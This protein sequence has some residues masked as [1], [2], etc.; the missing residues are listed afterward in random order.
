MTLND[1]GRELVGQD[2]DGNVYLRYLIDAYGTAWEI[3][4]DEAGECI[5]VGRVPREEAELSQQPK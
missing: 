4:E 1:D 5:Q 2:E 3:F